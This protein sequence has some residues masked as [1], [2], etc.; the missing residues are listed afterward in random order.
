M[1]ACH[2]A[3]PYV[4]LLSGQ[5]APIDRCC[6]VLVSLQGG[7]L[8]AEWRRFHAACSLTLSRSDKGSQS[9]SLAPLVG[10]SL[11]MHSQPFTSIQTSVAVTQEQL[12]LN[13]TTLMCCC[14]IDLCLPL[15]NGFTY[16]GV[17]R[18]LCHDA[19]KKADRG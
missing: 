2:W 11:R 9:C 3:W 18:L 17:I 5:L 13:A 6:S 8:A 14:S 4:W 10:Q 16:L 7:R 1:A 12:P 19:S 15:C